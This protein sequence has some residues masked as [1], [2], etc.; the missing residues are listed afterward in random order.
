MAIALGI[1]FSSAHAQADIA[2]AKSAV[3]TVL[4]NAEGNLV[5]AE[6]IQMNITDWTSK[7]A[8]FDQRMNDLNNRVQALL[9]ECQG[10][11]PVD[12]LAVLQAR[13]DA[14]TSQLKTSMDQLLLERTDLLE[15]HDRLQARLTERG[16]QWQGIE[17]NLASAMQR[18]VTLCSGLSAA[19][20]QASCHVPGAPG[21]RTH[22]L[23]ARLDGQL[24]EH[25]PATH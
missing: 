21:P 19:E 18:F 7:Q 22:D 17:A 23:V 15:Q 8:N 11:Y 3:A 24:L 2:A 14:S 25:A 9:A 4:A 1:P 6:A 13:C 12:Q 5:T 10:S 16:D 20:F